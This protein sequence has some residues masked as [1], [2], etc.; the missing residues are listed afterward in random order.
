MNPS[1]FQDDSSMSPFQKKLLA[2]KE[3]ALSPFAKLFKFLHRQKKIDSFRF[4][5][6]GTVVLIIVTLLVFSGTNYFNQL[7]VYN[8]YEKTSKEVTWKEY[9]NLAKTEDVRDLQTNVYRTAWLPL[10]APNN[11]TAYQIFLKDGRAF[12]FRGVLDEDRTKE[13]NKI[14]LER[15]LMEKKWAVDQASKDSAIGSL[16]GSLFFMLSMIIILMIGQRA[17]ADI[18]VGKNFNL[19]RNNDTIKFKDIIGYD[20]VKLE[21]TETVH[22]LKNYEKMQ[23]RGIQTPKGILLTG[24]PGVGKTMFAKALANECGAGFLYATGSDFVELY[25]GTGAR[26]VRSLFANARYMA[27]CIIFI[28]E[29]DALGKRDG[30]GMDSER[31][32]T[33]NQM[34]AEMDGMNENKAILVV[35]ATN[36]QDKIDSALLRPGRFD[37][38]INIPNPDFKTRQSILEHY[39]AVSKKITAEKEFS[40]M[41]GAVAAFQGMDAKE[42]LEAHAN[43]DGVK[44]TKKE[45][46]LNLARFA[47]ITAGMSGADLKNLIDEA[48]N[49]FMRNNPDFD[50]IT[51][52]NE[53]LEEALEVVLL[54][55]SKNENTKSEKDRVAFHELGHARVGKTLNT[56]AFVQKISIA[57]RGGALGYTLQTP[58]EE[59]RLLTPT[60]L[61]SQITSLLGGRAAEEVMIGE[62]SSGCADDLQRAN[63]IAQKMVELWGMGRTVGMFATQPASPLNPS[64]HL[65]KEKIEADINEILTGC[66]ARAVQ[67]IEEN[68]QWMLDKK[69]LLIERI[70]LEHDELF[71]EENTI[72]ITNEKKEALQLG[73]EQGGG[74]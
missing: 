68:R 57:G 53:D 42:G 60:E 55:V 74:I 10:G 18:I 49:I 66:Y 51:I 69:D 39:N 15:N 61:K 34:L 56:N 36:H 22:K 70:S 67:I 26:R 45:M 3:K 31:L 20:E 1:H 6:M 14:I 50:S 59:L 71:L 40:P 43:I 54:G 16:V 9:L 58:K 32:A 33:I 21:F 25:V 46:P 23:K 65:N 64:A 12:D 63:A 11:K 13:I 72:E 35:A 48:K 17:F 4:G 47:K 7:S 29:I 28:D 41:N 5:M 73:M 24:S 30:Y 19:T 38:K 2:A 27:P 8:N 44:L 62:V 52:S 37:K